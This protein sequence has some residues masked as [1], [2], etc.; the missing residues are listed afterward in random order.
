MDPV[1]L[2]PYTI[3]SKSMGKGVYELKNSD[4]EVLKKKANINR[5]KKF[6]RRQPQQAKTVN[7]DSQGSSPPAKKRKFNCKVETVAMVGRNI[8]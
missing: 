6:N 2:E 5:L 7:S 1:W 8:A 4:G 3:I